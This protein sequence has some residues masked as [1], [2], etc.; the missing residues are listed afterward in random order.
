MA[1]ERVLV[2]WRRV[3][4]VGV[5]DGDVEGYCA[6]E[7]GFQPNARGCKRADEREGVPGA[8][9]R[10]GDVSMRNRSGTELCRR[11]KKGWMNWGLRRHQ[12][13]HRKERKTTITDMDRIEDET[14]R[15]NIYSVDPSSNSPHPFSLPQKIN[16]LLPRHILPICLHRRILHCALCLNETRLAHITESV[17]ITNSSGRKADEGVL[18]RRG[19]GRWRHG[20][21]FL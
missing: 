12:G 17:R 1:T 10:K 2:V 5:A 11:V 18:R 15:A 9:A 14:Y 13:T 21:V 7:Q 8:V 3:R 6:E 4:V 20:A 16:P 19:W